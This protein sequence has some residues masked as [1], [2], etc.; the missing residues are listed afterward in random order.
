MPGFKGQ[1]LYKV[2]SKSRVAI[3]A[4]MRS[5]LNPEAMSTFTITRGFEQ[6]IYLYPLDRWSAMESKI[7]AL[8]PYDHHAR[9]FTRLIMM[10]AE[11]ATLDTQ[12]RVTLPKSLAQYAGIRQHAF[13]LGS[14]DKVEIWNQHTFQAYLEAQTEDFETLAQRAMS[15]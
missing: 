4:K 11:E 3:P 7:A 14:L 8:S 1:A 15:A 13:I 5:A 12:G 10:W 2:D 6:C 9:A